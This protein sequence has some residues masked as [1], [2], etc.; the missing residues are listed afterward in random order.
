M[1]GKQEGKESVIRA[2]LELEQEC[3]EAGV[4]QSYGL[5]QMRLV[6]GF[7]GRVAGVLA[8]SQRRVGAVW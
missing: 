5:K 6:C 4:A 1:E 2:L 7:A 3:L 8:L